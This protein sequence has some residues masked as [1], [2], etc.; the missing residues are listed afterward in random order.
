MAAHRML[1]NDETTGGVVLCRKS[2]S[3]S[4]LSTL[5]LDNIHSFPHKALVDSPQPS[6]SAFSRRKTQIYTQT[7]L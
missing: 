4:T 2:I 3:A 1:L 6:P 5:H 7:P